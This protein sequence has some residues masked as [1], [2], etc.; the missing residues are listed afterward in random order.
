LF[1]R[2]AADI[3]AGGPVASVLGDREATQRSM[4]GLR[5]MGAVHRLVLE[6][7][8]PDLAAFYPSV[9][10]RPDADLAWA[11]FRA[12]LADRPEEVRAGSTIQSRRTTPGAPP[13]WSAVSSKLPG[14]P[15]CHCGS[16][17]WARAPAFI[18]AGIT[19][20][21]RLGG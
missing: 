10:G 4:L 17:R 12:L 5:L 21:T 1:E 19:T 9:G 8:A 18:S 20:S 2:A 11:A 14:P 3:E 16:S 15:D 7:R 13:R 6:G